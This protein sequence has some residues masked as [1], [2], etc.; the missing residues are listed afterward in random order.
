MAAR[1]HTQLIWE[2]VVKHG[3]QTPPQLAKEEIQSLGVRSSGATL[4]LANAISQ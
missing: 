2:H 4:T 3:M 1:F